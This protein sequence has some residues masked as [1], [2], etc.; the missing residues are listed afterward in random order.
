MAL[1]AA[2]PSE[3]VQLN[4][5]GCPYDAEITKFLP[6]EYCHQ[7]YQCL[8]GTPIAQ[9]C[10]NGLFFNI[11][12]DTCDW[13]LDVDCGSRMIIEF[14]P[15]IAVEEDEKPGGH[16]HSDPS[17]APAI[18]AAEDS[19]G[20][21]VAHENCNEFYICQAG[22]PLTLQCP[23]N[24]LYNYD[25]EQCDWPQNVKCGART[26]PTPEKEEDDKFEPNS[27]PS[28]A[29]VACAQEDSDGVLLAHENCNRFFKC[30][31][32]KPVVLACPSGLVYNIEHEYCDWSYNVDC[33]YRTIAEDKEEESPNTTSPEWSPEPGTHGHSDPSQAPA[34]CAAEGS[35]S[36]LVA[37][38]NCKQFY[39]CDRGVPVVLD[40][41]GFLRYSP[42]YE[43]CDWPQNVDCTGRTDY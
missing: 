4:S 39:K 40:C 41:P 7:F 26:L 1:T 27:I 43:I 5:A 12:F 31:G 37:H 14:K 30:S 3:H 6:H 2:K 16:G 11:E 29:E 35:D 33:G 9:V 22:R 34:I 23:I 25:N 19:E 21:L 18:C 38:Q 32:G 10:P 15:E 20:V 13:P 8:R 17:K 36:V 28:D 24:L 42:K